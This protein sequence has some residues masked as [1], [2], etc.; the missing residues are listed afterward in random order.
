LQEL[1]WQVSLGDKDLPFAKR[2]ACLGVEIDLAK[3]HAREL[4]ICNKSGRVQS[5]TDDLKPYIDRVQPV[6]FKE[7]L[8]IRGRLA[9][10][11]G[12]TF[13]RVLAPTSRV[14]SKWVQR[15]ST[16]LVD[17]ELLLALIHARD[18]LL[19][20]GP[21]LLRPQCT[22]QPALIF[23]DGACEELTTIGGVLI[24][25]DTVQCFGAV[26]P[27]SVVSSWKSKLDQEQVIGQAEIFPVL[28]ARLT[29]QHLLK[30]RRCVFFL[31]NESARIALVRSY[32]PVLSSLNILMDV[33]SWDYKYSVDPWYARVPTCA[34]VSDGPSRMS[35]EDMSFFDA[36]S[37]VKPVFP[38]EQPVKFLL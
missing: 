32:S 23:T 18:Y 38:G 27:D 36:Y 22:D 1:G 16:A 5:I 35:L 6:G 12:Q 9:Y 19:S 26:V 30:G 3:L 15:K 34:N 14:L 4:E 13:G 31:D 25:N 11:E 33:A 24:L 37:V 10:A 29:W 8:S 7:A 17:E 28:V 2:F 20:A 21:R